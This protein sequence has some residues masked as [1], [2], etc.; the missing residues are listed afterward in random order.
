MVTRSFSHPCFGTNDQEQAQADDIAGEAPPAGESTSAALAGTTNAAGHRTVVAEPSWRNPGRGLWGGF[1]AGV[2]VRVAEVESRAAGEPLSITLS[3]VSTLYPGE[4]DVRALCLRQGRSVG[5]WEVEIRQDPS[6]SV[7]V[8]AIITVAR[9]PPTQ[10]FGFVHMPAAPPP[11]EWPIQERNV[12]HRG[13]ASFEW[14]TPQPHFPAAG[15]AARSVAWVRPRHGVWDKAVLT[16]LTDNSVPRAMYALGPEIGQATLSLTAYLHATAAQL[17]AIRDDFVLVEYHGRVG[18]GGASD[19]YSR[20]W[21]RDGTLLATSEQLV[22]YHQPPANPDDR[23]DPQRS[24]RAT[25]DHQ[26]ERTAE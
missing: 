24:R 25:S 14:R 8:H 11:E 3:Y 26:H 2:C 15:D 23:I 19:D 21:S 1:T 7:G 12:D 4:L 17:A 22:W 9:R 5:V 16:M 6:G 10:P 18:G 13:D 20:Y